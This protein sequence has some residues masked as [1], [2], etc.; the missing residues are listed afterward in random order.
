MFAQNGGCGY[1]HRDKGQRLRVNITIISGRRIAVRSD[2]ADVDAAIIVRLFGNANDN[3]R[4]R[5]KTQ[6]AVTAGFEPM[7]N[8]PMEFETT[9]HA[10]AVLHFQVEVTKAAAADGVED[11]K[12]AELGRSARREKKVEITAD[13]AI[14]LRSTRL[15]YRTLQLWEV[16]DQMSDG[17]ATPVRAGLLLVHL[18]MV[19]M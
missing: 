17:T 13:G 4:P 9:D 1:V 19:P 18:E 8:Q 12:G 5:Q 14:P 7:W 11:A 10:L 6:P 3:A 16:S 2:G 15:G